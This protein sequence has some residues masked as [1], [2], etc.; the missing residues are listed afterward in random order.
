MFDILIDVY[1]QTLSPLTSLDR[2]LAAAYQSHMTARRALAIV[3]AEEAREAE[4]SRALM[5]KTQDLEQ[6]AVEALR[7]GRD[8]LATQAAEAI[9]AMSGD[10]RA[11]EQASRHFAAEVALARR[12]VE[13][14]RRRL[15]DLDRGRRMARIDSALTGTIHGS[16]TGLDSLSEAEIALEKVRA[17]NQNARAIRHEMSQPA[18]H[19]IE[20]MSEAGF[21]RPTH[22]RASDVLAR[23]RRAAEQ[24]VATLIESNP[25][26]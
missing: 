10:I 26:S 9:A 25:K 7:A 14:Q 3:I 13:A 12:E 16:E 21:G 15:S 23:L 6:R 19:L 2:S 11:T 1:R 22:I 18:E 4:R 24:P 20:Q 5:T 17:D 8:D